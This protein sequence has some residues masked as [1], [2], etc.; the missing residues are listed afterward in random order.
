[1]IGN[2]I[3]Y[4]LT[5]EID[6]KVTINGEASTR[7]KIKLGSVVKIEFESVM[8]RTDFYIDS[9]QA[10]QYSN[11]TGKNVMMVTDGCVGDKSV[12][13]EL[14]NIYFLSKKL[15]LEFGLIIRIEALKRIEPEIFDRTKSGRK[16]FQFKQFAFVS[17]K[18]FCN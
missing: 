8:S 7:S 2:G 9:C 10:T 3:T 15:K 4:T 18:P 13:R 16:S 14:I 6:Y 12:S 5:P 17:S 11:G 1:M